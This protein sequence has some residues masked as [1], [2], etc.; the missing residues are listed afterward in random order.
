M[1]VLLSFLILFF[2]I[3]LPNELKGLLFYMQASGSCKIQFVSFL[4]F[5]Y[6]PQFL[7]YKIILFFFFLTHHR[8]LSIHFKDMNFS[9]KI[10]AGNLVVCVTKD[11]LIIKSETPFNTFLVHEIF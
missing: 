8:N 7:D 10:S 11:C 4:H 6:I 2:N 3:G 5:H 9:I 1:V